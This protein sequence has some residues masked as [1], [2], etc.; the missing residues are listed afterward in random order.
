LPFA[1]VVRTSGVAGSGLAE[2]VAQLAERIGADVGDTSFAAEQRELQQ[3]ATAVRAA[4]MLVAGDPELAQPELISLE[5]R[6]A[7]AGLAAAQTET[8]AE[9]V[10]ERI[11]SKFCVGK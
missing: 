3:A 2:L 8:P 9:E 11:F 1:A 7:L 6:A 4:C 10:L 5:L